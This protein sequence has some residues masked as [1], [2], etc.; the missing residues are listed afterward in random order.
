MGC[1]Y[2]FE[3][4]IA[5]DAKATSKPFGRLA[6]AEDSA[7]EYVPCQGLSDEDVPEFECCREK[8]LPPARSVPGSSRVLCSG[9][10]AVEFSRSSAS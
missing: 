2:L 3:A 8:G 1:S 5:L 6:I 7:I 9:R 4:V 10:T